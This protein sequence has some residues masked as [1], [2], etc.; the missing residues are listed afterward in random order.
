MTTTITTMTIITTITATVITPTP[1]P[2]TMTTT[3]TLQREQQLYH[4]LQRRKSSINELLQIPSLPCPFVLQSLPANVSS[5]DRLEGF[6]R[7]E[8]EIY[9]QVGAQW[10]CAQERSSESG[11]CSS[12]CSWPSTFQLCWGGP[13]CPENGSEWTFSSLV[14]AGWMWQMNHDMQKSLVKC[15]S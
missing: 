6:E 12:I 9:M 2:T 4:N 5:K 10:P 7:V 3:T 1:T 11:D 8:Y 13:H 15:C 14:A